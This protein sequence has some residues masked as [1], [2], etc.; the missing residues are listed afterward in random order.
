M[1]AGGHKVDDMEEDRRT[2]IAALAAGVVAVAVSM[3]VNEGTYDILS[4][5]VGLSL[6]FV[7]MAYVIGRPRSG[8]QSVAVAAVLALTSLSVIGFFADRYYSQEP[9]NSLVEFIR[10]VKTDC[11]LEN[12]EG[13][14][15]DS[16]LGEFGHLVAWL[17]VLVSAWALDRG[18]QRF[19]A[20]VRTPKPN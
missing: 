9:I 2:D 13:C 11:Q 20:R 3:F 15:N 16:R 1:S 19:T 18:C 10:Y 17:V 6:G 12:K 5:I 4:A 14:S 8:F 7:I